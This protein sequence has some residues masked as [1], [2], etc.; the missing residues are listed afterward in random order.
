MEADLWILAISE[1]QALTPPTPFYKLSTILQPSAAILEN[2][3]PGKEER[4][5]TDMKMVFIRFIVEME[6]KR[7][8]LNILAD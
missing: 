5:G 4:V 8:K 2:K 1:T 3:G 7:S 6:R